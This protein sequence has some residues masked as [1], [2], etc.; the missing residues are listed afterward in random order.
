MKSCA[1]NWGKMKDNN[2][3]VIGAPAHTDRI[4][5]AKINVVASFVFSTPVAI[6][7]PNIDDIDTIINQKD[8]AMSMY[9]FDRIHLESKKDQID[10]RERIRYQNT[11]ARVKSKQIQ[12]LKNQRQKG[13]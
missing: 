13:K 9:D 5:I 8:N 12:Q 7:R 4:N 1:R 2:I 11:Y 3:L 6:Y 10:R